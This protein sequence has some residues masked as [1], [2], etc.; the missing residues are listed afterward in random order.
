MT[1]RE[2]RGLLS[3]QGRN[4]ESVVT[5]LPDSSLDA[6]PDVVVQVTG[7]GHLITLG[8]EKGDT[9][10]KLTGN[11]NTKETYL[12]RFNNT[13]SKETC[14]GKVVVDRNGDRGE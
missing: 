8:L 7:R 4:R 14:R 9:R 11:I 1:S 12:E 10:Q 2:G 13:G 3:N 5:F 6:Y